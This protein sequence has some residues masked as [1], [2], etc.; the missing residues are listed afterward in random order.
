M[1]SCCQSHEDDTGPCPG[2]Q[3]EKDKPLVVEKKLCFS[4]NQICFN[5]T[6]F[7]EYYNMHQGPC[8]T[9]A[10]TFL[11][12]DLVADLSY[13]SHLSETDSDGLHRRRKGN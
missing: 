11:N 9:L 1:L 8:C 10:I 5:S 12:L 6:V 4:L 2:N 13:R 7:I 3:N